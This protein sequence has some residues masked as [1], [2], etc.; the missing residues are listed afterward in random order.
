MKMISTALLS[1][2]KIAA[3]SICVII[4]LTLLIISAKLLIKE[5]NSAIDDA[6]LAGYGAGYA[7]AENEYITKMQ[8]ALAEK[9]KEVDEL[10]KRNR[11]IARTYLQHKDKVAKLQ[12]KLEKE[13][14]KYETEI[15]KSNACNLTV[16]GVQQTNDA[17]SFYRGRD[18]S[19]DSGSSAGDAREVS[20]ITA[21]EFKSWCDGLAADYNRNYGLLAS[22]MNVVKELKKKG[23]KVK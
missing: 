21:A 19:R 22:V 13:K 1:K 17:L 2:Y 8:T 23:V 7:E 12:L 14:N 4:A 10:N 6:R 9:Q 11:A 3:T 5:Y 20:D 18:E 16:A 15:R